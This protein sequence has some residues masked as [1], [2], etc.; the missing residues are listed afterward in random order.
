MSVVFAAI[1]PHGGLVLEEPTPAPATRAAME[2][3]GRRLAVAE[4]EAT[5]LVTPHNVHVED[6]FAV[7]TAGTLVS[8]ELTVETHLE[9]AEG[10]LAAIK[11]AAPAVGVFYGGNDPATAEMP[12]DWATEIPLRFLGGDALRVVVV[13]PARDR[14][15]D[16]HVE[17]GRALASLTGRHALVVSADHSH[18]HAEGGPYHVDTDAAEAYDSTIVELVRENRLERLLELEELAARS[19][20]DSL[21]QLV[22]LHGALGDGFGGELLSYE[23][24]T[25]FG[26]LCAAYEPRK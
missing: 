19:L 9:L 24:P 21:W 14:P 26:M 1:A 8:E 20:A 18:T 2:E 3:L 4:P 16:E 7:I 10:A 23:A 22:M 12:M 17:V 15:L 11:C 6:H 5:I 25:Y 13:A